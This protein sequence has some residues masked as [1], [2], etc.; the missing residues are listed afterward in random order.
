MVRIPSAK[1]YSKVSDYFDAVKPAIKEMHRQVGS[2]LVYKDG[3]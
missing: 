1:T 2:E 3:V